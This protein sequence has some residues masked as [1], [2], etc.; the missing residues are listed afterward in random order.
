MIL[1]DVD[2]YKLAERTHFEIG[3]IFN[4]L[5]S[6]YQKS[7]AYHIWLVFYASTER[8]RHIRTIIQY[9]RNS[10]L[11]FELKSKNMKEKLKKKRSVQSKPHQILFCFFQ[12]LISSEDFI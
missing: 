3:Y 12:T 7:I 8:S 9:G 11:V 10:N 5:T 6:T 2:I 1:P 4:Y